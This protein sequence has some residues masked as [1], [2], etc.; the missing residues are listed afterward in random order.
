MPAIIHHDIPTP[1]PY[2]QVETE[3]RL[4]E[5]FIPTAKIEAPAPEAFA[6]T[7]TARPSLLEKRRRRWSRLNARS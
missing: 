1:V 2:V 4:G 5:Y 7:S 3:K 6:E